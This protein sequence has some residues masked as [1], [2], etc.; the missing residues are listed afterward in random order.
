MINMLKT[1]KDKVENFA[2]QLGTVKREVIWKSKKETIS[3]IKNFV[4]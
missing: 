2:I 4:D 3:K 1:L